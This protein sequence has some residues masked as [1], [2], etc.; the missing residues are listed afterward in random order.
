MTTTRIATTADSRTRRQSPP[1]SGPVILPPL[2]KPV[3]RTGSPSRGGVASSNNNGGRHDIYALTVPR[4]SSPQRLRTAAA[5]TT[6]P[7]S[8]LRP[9]AAP[10]PPLARPATRA[11]YQAAKQA[12]AAERSSHVAAQ[13]MEAFI[14][15]HEREERHDVEL[16]EITQFNGISRQFLRGTSA[17]NHSTN[18]SATMAGSSSSPAIGGLESRRTRRQHDAGD[19]GVLAASGQ[20]SPRAHLGRVS[21]VYRA[22]ELRTER[23]KQLSKATYSQPAAP[24]TTVDATANYEQRLHA[25]KEAQARAAIEADA[26]NRLLW[27]MESEERARAQALDRAAAARMQA[28]DT[29][30]RRAAT[31]RHTAQDAVASAF[32]AMEATYIEAGDIAK[33]SIGSALAAALR[34]ACRSEAASAIAVETIEAALVFKSTQ[35]L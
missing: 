16:A 26:A 12:A 24:G 31:A 28:A 18:G 34:Q 2:F 9:A 35:V 11:D 20:R 17:L 23:C 25:V 19:G 21:A 32:L 13:R 5:A 30:R 8:T 4:S 29:L 6:A 22:V 7:T 3:R 15:K 10:L 14:T 1:R 33:K 27:I